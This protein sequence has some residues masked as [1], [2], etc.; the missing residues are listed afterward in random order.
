M[1][2][3]GIRDIMKRT[4]NKHNRRQ[5]KGMSERRSTYKRNMFV[6][7]V[8]GITLDNMRS[9]IIKPRSVSELGGFLRV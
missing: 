3:S 6:R 2:G 4:K 1:I 7:H 8:A 5:G 9:N